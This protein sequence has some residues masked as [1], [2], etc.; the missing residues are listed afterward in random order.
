MSVLQQARSETLPDGVQ[1]EVVVEDLNRP[2]AFALA[3]DGR[4]FFTEKE[5]GNVRVIADDR[6]LPDPVLT[7]KVA[8][9]AE[10][11]LLGIAI[12]PD[13]DSNHYVWVYHSLAARDNHGEKVNR[14][15][16]F[17]ER[18]NAAIGVTPV[19]TSPNSEGDG[20]HNGGNLHFGPDGMLYVSIGED[21][22]AALAQR[23]DDP[24][25]KIHRFNPGAPLT[26]PEDNPFYDGDGPNVDSIYTFG[27]RN[28]FDFTFDPQTGGRIFISENG[29]GCDDEINLAVP[30]GNYGWH[31]NY[32]CDDESGARVV[33]DAVPPMLFWTPTT[34]PVGIVVYDGDDVPSWRGDVFFCT[35]LDAVLHHLT[36]N[37][38]R[39]RFVKHTV[40]DGVFCQTDVFMGPEGGLYFVAGGGF[41]QGTLYRIIQRP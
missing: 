26:A 24:R 31:S 19:F 2:V 28:P 13:F 11:G 40:L 18:D 23:L 33:L 15:V 39:D 30:A 1:V 32:D 12:D 35:Y 17:T 14:V 10:Q 34:A 25:G 5:S 8:T 20:T 3:P 41:E 16:R 36:L 4:I 9:S 22:Q 38:A 37:A 27:H 21:N 29:P 6:L 7:L